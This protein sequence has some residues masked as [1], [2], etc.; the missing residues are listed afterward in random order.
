M[1][2][3]LLITKYISNIFIADLKYTFGM[4]DKRKEF[5]KKSDF[6]NAGSCEKEPE[7]WVEKAVEHMEMHY[8]LITSVPPKNVKLTPDDDLIYDRFIAE[9]PDFKLDLLDKEHLRTEESKM[10]WRE[11][12][13]GFGELVRDSKLGTLIRID[14][15]GGYTEDNTLIVLRLQFLAIEIA[16]NKH[17][18]NDGLKRKNDL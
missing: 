1:Q 17:G 13:E 12:T 5:L 16:R 10:K 3:E 15:S 7:A 9:F 6:L 18:L 14:S 8:D 11:F 4:A 2:F